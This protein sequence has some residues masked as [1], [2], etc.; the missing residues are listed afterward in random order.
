ML[1]VAMADGGG[2]DHQRAIGN[3]LGYS[4]VLF[5]S[6]QH[7]RGAHGGTRALKCH[8]IRIHYPE[9]LKS[10]VAH[11]PSSRADVEG[12]ARVH[13]DDAQTI[14]FS[15]NRQAVCILRQREFVASLL[16]QPLFTWA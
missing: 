6:G 5:S 2:S 8:I 7:L 14:E 9:M 3:R 4:F 12:I 16:P 11:R 13:Q 15:R 10:K 1:Q